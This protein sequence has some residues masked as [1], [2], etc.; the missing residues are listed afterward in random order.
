MFS[1]ISANSNISALQ[2]KTFS[3]VRSRNQTTY[4]L[5]GSVTIL[6][7]VFPVRIK[8][9]ASFSLGGAIDFQ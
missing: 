8:V 6:L 3:S 5:V 7:Y 9:G 2:F 1:Y 4:S